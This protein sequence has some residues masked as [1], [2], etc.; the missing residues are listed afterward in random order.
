MSTLNLQKLLDGDNI[1]QV[2]DKINE[3]FNQLSINGGGPLGKKGEQGPPGLPGLRGQ[4]GISGDDGESGQNVSLVGNDPNWGVLYSGNPGG[5]IA[6]NADSAIAEGYN[7]GDVWIDNANGIFYVIVENTPDVYDFVPYP[8]SPVALSVGELWSQDTESNTNNNT[9]TQG[10]RNR[11]RYSTLS[12]TSR[13]DTNNPSGQN[14]GESSQYDDLASN[15]PAQNSPVWGYAR[16]AY[17]L[18]IDNATGVDLIVRVSDAFNGDSDIH[19]GVKNDKLVPLIYLSNGSALPTA[20]QDRNSFGILMDSHTKTVLG[21]QEKISILTIGSS[22]GENNSDQLFVRTGKLGTSREIYFQGK[23]G[24][25]AFMH[26]LD[27]RSDGKRTT[28]N[29][30]LWLGIASITTPSSSGEALP[31]SDND[32]T[33]L[34][35]IE[36]RLYK[37]GSTPQAGKIN[38]YTNNSGLIA[39]RRFVMSLDEQGGLGLGIL[40]PASTYS[41]N[42]NTGQ[43]RIV[44]RS[45]NND[46]SNRENVAAFMSEQLSDQNAAQGAKL[47]IGFSTIAGETRKYKAILRSILEDTGGITEQSP[48]I[49]QP[50]SGIGW[51]VSESS[52]INATGIGQINPTAKLH[53]GGNL[54]IDLVNNGTGEFL[55]RNSSTNEILRR[56]PSQVLEDIG[57]V[58]GTG[59]ATRIAFWTGASTLGND[60]QLF[61]DNNNKRLGVGTPTPLNIAHFKGTTN[62]TIVNIQQSINQGLSTVEFLNHTG[63]GLGS[64]GIVSTASPVN[65]PAM[66]V[67]RL[68]IRTFVAGTN[69]EI[70]TA[71]TTVTDGGNIFIRPSLSGGFDATDGIIFLERRVQMIDPAL[72]LGNQLAIQP[73][74]IE[75]SLSNE[76][77][78]WTYSGS[79]ATPSLSATWTTGTPGPIRF[80][81]FYDRMIKFSLS[82]HVLASAGTNP[83]PSFPQPEFIQYIVYTRPNTSTSFTGAPYATGSN[84]IVHEKGLYDFANGVVNVVIPACHQFAIAFRTVPD[85][86]TN[87]PAGSGLYGKFNIF[88]HKFGKNSQNMCIP[89]A[90]A[91]IQIGGN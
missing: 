46:N 20:I 38:F 91:G 53:I 31:F 56:T 28:G 81:T 37:D 80:S 23:N 42:D 85:S 17:K 49:I 39:G 89:S 62:D 50:N 55:T 35:G 52:N 90:S 6:G 24:D 63:A 69:I 74:S 79:T 18:S 43:H 29:N 40:Q 25:N 32:H 75:F 21:I 83:I 11:N 47:V 26:L 3:N 67:N 8:I 73:N 27:I 16:K 2:I 1:A 14:L 71:N 66:G 59:V 9:E 78:V 19:Y 45:I 82:D 7:V 70:A 86:N 84:W 88:E 36:N 51:T 61:W 13:F 65:S 5:P 22:Q 30:S 64:V 77:H 33:T 87:I 58:S 12:L 41:A 15:Y 34:F 60:I 76:Y 72:P 44:V 57:G 68:Q 10:I 48:L 4:I 54:K